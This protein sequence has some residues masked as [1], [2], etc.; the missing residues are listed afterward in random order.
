[1]QNFSKHLQ[2]ETKYQGL[3]G[4]NAESTHDAQSAEEEHAA[5]APP[6]GATPQ[7]S[8]KVNADVTVHV[9]RSGKKYHAAGC[10]SFAKSDIPMT[11]AQAKARGYTSCS[12][13]RPLE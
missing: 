9:T 13:C 7:S 10:T 11:L 4:E 2:H 3:Q 5:T 8:S 12:R 6:T 1:M